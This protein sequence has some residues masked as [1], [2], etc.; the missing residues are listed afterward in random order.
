MFLGVEP[1]LEGFYSFRVATIVVK[2]KNKQTKNNNN[3]KTKKK[4]RREESLEDTR[5]RY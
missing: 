2:Q 1:S 4:K 3:K 5:K